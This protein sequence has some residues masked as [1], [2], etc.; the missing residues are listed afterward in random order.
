MMMDRGDVLPG[1]IA[2]PFEPPAPL[3]IQDR[4]VSRCL[5][6]AIDTFEGDW[7]RAAEWM[8]TPNPALGDRTPFEAASDEEG[9][10]QVLT[11]LVRIDHGIYG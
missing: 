10:Q 7:E 1:E 4:R 11:I 9:E 8:R 2:G 3:P 6:K 5:S